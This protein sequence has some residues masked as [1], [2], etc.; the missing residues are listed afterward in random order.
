MSFK[1]NVQS[2]LVLVSYKIYKINL[3]A[4]LPILKNEIN[5][6]PTSCGPSKQMA[7]VDQILL[8]RLFQIQRTLWSERVGKTEIKPQS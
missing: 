1:G 4:T 7:G 6:S 5:T 8:E 2:I 3:L